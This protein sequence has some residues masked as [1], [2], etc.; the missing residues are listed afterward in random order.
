MTKAC[1]KSANVHCE[2]LARAHR[3]ITV[4]LKMTDR[5][6]RKPAGCN[7][8]TARGHGSHKKTLE[9]SIGP[10]K[11]NS[12]SHEVSKRSQEEQ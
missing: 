4:D 7:G 2:L 10:W 1:R 11:L 5:K 9:D 12:W 6:N 8:K 3:K